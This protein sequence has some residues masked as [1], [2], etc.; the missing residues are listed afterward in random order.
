MIK[1][2]YVS[3]LIVLLL[4]CSSKE[5]NIFRKNYKKNIAYNHALQKTEK[6]QFYDTENNRT[7]LL[8][9]ATYL[10]QKKMTKK[11]IHDEI[12]IFGVSLED[13]QENHFNLK[14][15]SLLLNNKNVKNIKILKE[16]DLLLKHISFS[17][18]WTKFYMV[19]FPY[20]SSKSLNLKITS[21]QYSTGT[22]SF[23]KG[24]K[25]TLHKND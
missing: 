6:I 3:I 7:K 21:P 17:S 12:F 14:N 24:A 13:T 11:N 20:I 2:V 23:A 15:F 10:S 5:E 22:A 25:Y 19:H 9:T 18:T 1:Y 16:E 4:G 8:I